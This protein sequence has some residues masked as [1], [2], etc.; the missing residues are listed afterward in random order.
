MTASKVIIDVEMKD[1]GEVITERVRDWSSQT[2]S[3]EFVSMW[4]VRGNEETK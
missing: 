4:L 3:A 1:C 2:S